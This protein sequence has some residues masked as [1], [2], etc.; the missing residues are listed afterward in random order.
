M[1]AFRAKRNMNRNYF[2]EVRLKPEWTCGDNMCTI[3]DVPK[4]YCTCRHYLVDPHKL[5]VHGSYCGK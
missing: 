4:L 2:L 1:F 5:D 3:N